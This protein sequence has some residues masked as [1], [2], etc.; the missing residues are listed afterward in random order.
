MKIVLTD[1]QYAELKKDHYLEIIINADTEQNL[2]FEF[3][4]NGTFNYG[5]INQKRI[6]GY[7]SKFY[8]DG[9]DLGKII[10]TKP[11][12]SSWLHD[13]PVCPSCAA[14]MIYHFEHC[15]KCGQTLDWRESD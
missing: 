15:P 1:E 10:P 3:N 2:Y 12:Y 6:P 8:F 11:R 5:E 4:D 9:D 14:D 13:K 7:P